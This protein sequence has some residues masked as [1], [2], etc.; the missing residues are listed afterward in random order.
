MPKL[1][2]SMGET[3]DF[4]MRLQ[5]ACLG[6]HTDQILKELGYKNAEIKALKSEKIVRRT[7]RMLDVN[8]DPA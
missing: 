4:T 8:E 6:A 5:P 3:T 7:D 1:P 2:L